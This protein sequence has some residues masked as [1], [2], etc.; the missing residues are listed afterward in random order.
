MPAA[1]Q[2]VGVTVGVSVTVFVMVF[3]GMLVDVGVKVLVLE[4]GGEEGLD[5]VL[6]PCSITQ[7]DI[8][9]INGMF[10]MNIFVFIFPPIFIQDFL[11]TLSK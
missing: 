10:K 11:M 4:G 3:V 5:L 7:A 2:M 1:E 9:N 8:K 6:H